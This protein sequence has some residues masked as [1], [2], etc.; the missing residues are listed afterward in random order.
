MSK[1][2]PII[3]TTPAFG[4]QSRCLKQRC[5]L[6]YSIHA[7]HAMVLTTLSPTQD[8]ASRGNSATYRIESALLTDKPLLI[9][10]PFFGYKVFHDIVTVLDVYDDMPAPPGV[11]R[12]SLKYLQVTDLTIV[13]E[14][15]PE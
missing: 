8:N 1:P 10:V 15:A 2:C 3:I 7:Q 14:R 12:D 13:T 11:L 5:Q 6:S 4:S 9:F